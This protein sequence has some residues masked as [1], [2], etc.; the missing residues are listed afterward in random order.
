M[1]QRSFV[2]TSVHK[3][4]QENVKTKFDK[5]K[6]YHGTPSA[7]AKKAFYHTCKQMNK[8]IHNRCTL[9]VVVKEVVPTTVNGFKMLLPL[10]D[11]KGEEVKHKYA[12]KLMRYEPKSTDGKTVTFE[13]NM[14]ITFK[15]YAKI[16]KSF[17]RV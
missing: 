13:K 4:A 15:Y 12:L 6:V 9:S 3:T 5:T 2:V 16:V 14:A 10:I 11:S 8:K 17:G 1:S 7:A